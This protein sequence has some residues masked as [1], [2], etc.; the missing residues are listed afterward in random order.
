MIYKNL[1]TLFHQD[2]KEW[3]ALYQVLFN[4]P[5]SRHIDIPIKLFSSS[6]APAP[7][8][9]YYTEDMMQYM[10]EITKNYSSL[11]DTMRSL[12]P[13]ALNQFTRNCL[14]EEIQSSNDIEGVRSTRK[15]ISAAIDEQND[16]NPVKQIR[17]WSVANKYDKLL[18]QEN[19]S[20]ATSMDLR[21]FYD[22]FILD[23]IK[24]ADPKDIP[25]GKIFRA[26][27]VNVYSAKAKTIHQGAFP[28][29]NI[30]KYMNTALE[31][32]HDDSIPSLIRISAYHYL[33]GY[34]H[35]FYDGNGR[36][37]RFITSYYLSKIFNPLVAIRLSLT[38]KKSLR[39]YYKLFETTNAYR[40]CG[41]LTP[42]ISGFLW[43]ILKSIT[44]VNELLCEKEQTLQN[45]AKI[46][47]R[48][49]PKQKDYKIY[50]I[51]L[52]AALFSQEGAS[53]EEISH[54]LGL[55]PR[56]LRDKIASYPSSHIIV[57]KS[58]RAHRYQ[59]NLEILKQTDTS[60]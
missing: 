27:P 11:V 50:Y 12:P 39:V 28:E 10:E 57:N 45:D 20:F 25:D 6:A 7:A 15:E 44:R 4:F 5:L 52:Q 41:D 56:T 48:I 55:M 36:T 34:I 35:P 19:I 33:F 32:L 21:N 46:V 54:A 3:K 40:N 2:E 58:H 47:N 38:I 51:L 14:I 59:L 60:I 8:F 43:L 24:N 31:F 9:F 53:L 26:G 49:I 16:L 23:E 17:M 30:I 22:D 18:K 42:F 29:E 37:S 13:V 1:L